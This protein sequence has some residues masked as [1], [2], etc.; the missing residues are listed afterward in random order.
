M[1]RGLITPMVGMTLR[2]TLDRQRKRDMA[3]EIRHA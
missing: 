2:G 1:F 3:G